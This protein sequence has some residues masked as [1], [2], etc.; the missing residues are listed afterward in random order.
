MEIASVTVP[1]VERKFCHAFLAVENIPLEALNL[2]ERNSKNHV[3][4]TKILEK[5]IAV[6][7][8]VFTKSGFRPYKIVAYYCWIRK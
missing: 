4:N 7:D 6:N 8:N 3:G 2:Y 5:Q 1:K